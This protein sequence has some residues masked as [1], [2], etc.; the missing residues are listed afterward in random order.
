MS[1]QGSADPEAVRALVASHPNWYHQIELAPGLVTPGAHGS[2]AALEVLDR[3]GLPADARGLRVLDIG[4]RD[5]FFAFE[6]ERRGALVQ[7]LDYAAPDVTGFAIASRVLGSRVGY[8][9]ANVYDLDPARFGTF[10]LVLF[11]GVLYHL[12]NP[13]LALDRVRSV[14]R[15]GGLIFVETQVTTAPELLGSDLP[16]WQFFP[17][18]ELHG[19]PTNMWAPNVPGLVRA[20]EECQIQVHQVVHA[21]PAGDRA[22][23]RGQAVSESA[24]EYYRKLD[25]AAGMVGL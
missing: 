15:P 23:A 22:W 24:L 21:G 18:G 16:V 4:C 20:L 13:M 17:R 1:A 10:D 12:R 8:A 19:D 25:S 9:V 7:G 2:L 14:L 5:G 3:M 11:L 6:L